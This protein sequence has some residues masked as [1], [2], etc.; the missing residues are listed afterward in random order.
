MVYK[1]GTLWKKIVSKAEHALR[2]GALCSLPTHNE[3]V[4]DGEVRFLIRILKSLDLKDIARKKQKETAE[5]SQNRTNPFLPYEEDLVVA[6]L[7]KTHIA[8]LNK[9]MVVDH[10]LLIVTRAFEDQEMLLT[11]G[12]FDA[13]GICL[14]EY[15]GLGFYNGGASAGASQSHKHLQM[16]PLPLAPEG[17]SV[18]IEP[19]FASAEFQGRI[20]IIPSFPFRNA[21]A[22]LDSRL[23]KSPM[24]SGPQ[25]FSLYS[26]MLS[27]LGFTLPAPG[28]PQR[29]SSPYC[30]LVTRDWMLLIPRSKE[31]FE[32]ISINAVGFAG[33]L[34]VRDPGQLERLKRAGPMTALRHVAV[35]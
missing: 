21:F 12:D 4:E 6:D 13:L 22:R 2:I 35:V 11:P 17:P 31:C 32:S 33:G 28:R 14:A 8:L 5:V 25:L 9:F 3:F 10:H 15:G 16:I 1:E 34:L 30:F 7:S 29:Q 26:E 19:L 18:P 27:R 24:H 20:G 23:L